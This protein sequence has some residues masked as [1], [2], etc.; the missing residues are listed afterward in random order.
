MR[1]SV[2]SLSF[3]CI[4]PP[5]QDCYTYRQ[6]VI[7]TFIETFRILSYCYLDYTS[8]IHPL[9]VIKSDHG[10][11]LKAL[12]DIEKDEA[13][14]RRR[15]GDEWQLRGPITY[16]PRPEVVRMCVCGGVHGGCMQQQSSLIPKR[17]AAVFL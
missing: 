7:A 15:A 12:V 8:A 1:V 9:P 17:L 2:T 3:L 6:W 11:H 10:L 4:E 16:V 13:G 14:M 5:R